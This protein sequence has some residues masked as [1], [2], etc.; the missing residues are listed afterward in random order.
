MPSNFDIPISLPT[1]YSSKNISKTNSERIIKKS[2]QIIEPSE[3]P[4]NL[5]KVRRK[6]IRGVI[7]HDSPSDR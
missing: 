7:K 1:G 3:I 6:T 4:E 2:Q 5:K